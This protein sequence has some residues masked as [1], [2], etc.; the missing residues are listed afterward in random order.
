[1]DIKKFRAAVRSYNPSYVTNI[2]PYEKLMKNAKK[3]RPTFH[4]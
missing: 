1:M 2:Q 4:N 3:R